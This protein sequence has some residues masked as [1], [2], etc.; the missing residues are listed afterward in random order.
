M[1]TEIRNGHCLCNAVTFTARGAPRFVS[2]CH[3]ET[4]RRASSASS[5]VWAGFREDQVTFAGDS[6][7]AF[8]SSPGVTRYFCGRCGSPIAFRGERWAGEVHV[9]VC[10][11]E[12]PQEMPPSSDHFADEK[13]PWAA[14]LGDSR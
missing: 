4:C 5:V 8:G 14:L 9:P 13:L 1:S 11:F 12:T 6:L 2:N 7:S 3:C 10:A